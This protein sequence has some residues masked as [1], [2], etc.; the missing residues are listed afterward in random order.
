MSRSNAVIRCALLLGATVVAFACT[1]SDVSVVEPA[2]ASAIFQSY[3]ALGN[4]IT[5]GYQ[6][7]GINDSTQKLSYAVLLAAAMHTRFAYPSLSMPG[8][9][10]PVS[11]LLTQAR[12]TLTGQPA[13]TG[14]TCLLRNPASVTAV[15]NNVAVPG[16]TSFD[17]TAPVGP[18]AS[19]LTELFLGGETMVQKALDAKPTFASIWIG[20]NDVLGP[21]TSGLI[22][23]ATPFVNFQRNYAIIVKA[24]LDSAPNLKGV[25]IAVAQVP[26]VPLMIP[27]AAFANPTVLGA[28]AQ[29][30][31]RAVALDPV[32]CAGAGLGSLIDFQYLAAIRA[33]PAALP[34]TIFCSPI[35]GGG[36]SDLGDFLVLD[37]TENASLTALINSYNAYIKAKADSIG[38][39]FFD[40]NPLLAGLKAN[41]SVPVFP[42]LTSATQPFGQFFSLDGVHP[43]AAAHVLIA[44][45]L[46]SVINAKY[47]TTLVKP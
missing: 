11:N 2:P 27:A 12:V 5:A 20:N 21:G 13:S 22:A 38:F 4:S 10:P 42:N 7:G 34:G 25:L 26:N 15:L 17:P 9:P 45:S 35:S 47:G 8:C 29:V 19:A 14:T 32:T 16:V 43:A 23:T 39:A 36:Q 46:V 24:L 33:R 18:A 30:A 37:P 41:G 1:N 6:S 31:G 40:P 3:V 28:A 44:D